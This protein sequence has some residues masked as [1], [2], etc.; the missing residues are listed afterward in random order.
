MDDEN[1]GELSDDDDL[2]P[3]FTINKELLDRVVYPVASIPLSNPKTVRS[4]LDFVKEVM[5]YQTEQNKLIG[6]K[7]MD[8]VVTKPPE[9]ASAATKVYVF[10]DWND[11]DTLVTEG[12]QLLHDMEKEPED[13][14]Y[15]AMCPECGVVFKKEN[16]VTVVARTQL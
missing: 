7:T 16:E 3:K 10:G 8:P 11:L 14:R 15:Y 5:R 13:N 12:R 2:N 4:H 9:D 1:I 6:V